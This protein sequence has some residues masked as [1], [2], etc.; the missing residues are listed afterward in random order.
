MTPV[1]IESHE[2]SGVV[3]GVS[4]DGPNPESQ[5]F[6]RCANHDSAIRLR[7]LLT[8]ATIDIIFDAPPGPESG[9]FVEVE[10]DG[11][12]INAGEWIKRDDGYWALRI[13]GVQV[14]T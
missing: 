6:F 12:S 5:N 1:I 10:R 3:W 9:R 8:I 2:D 11:K 4:L 13:E 14:R 7:D